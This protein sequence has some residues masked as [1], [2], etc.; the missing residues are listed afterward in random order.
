[1]QLGGYSL[2]AY[3]KM[4]TP[5]LAFIAAIWMLRLLLDAIG[6]PLDIVKYF[7]VTAASAI[8]VLLA[9]VNIHFSH[10][11][12]ALHVVICTA[13]ISAFSQLLIVS[14]IVFSVLSGT[15]NIFT[16]PEFS[17][18]ADPHHLRHIIGHLSFSIGAEVLLGSAMGN[19]LLLVLRLI[20]PTSKRKNLNQVR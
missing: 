15:P 2:K 3:F 14:A 1:M 20:L 4:L 10:F 6:V 19:L 18:A 7:S 9:T 16:A 17:L 12:G 5:L 8:A 13:I 11:G